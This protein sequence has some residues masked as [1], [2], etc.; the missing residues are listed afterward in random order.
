MKLLVSNVQF[1]FGALDKATSYNEEA[2]PKFYGKFLVRE[3]ATIKDIKAAIK[4]TAIDNFSSVP[5]KLADFLFEPDLDKYPEQEGCLI[6]N[7]AQEDKPKLFNRQGE[8]IMSKDGLIY[9]GCF[10]NVIINLW[11]YTYKGN[12]G[13]SANLNGLQFYAKG[14][15][16]GATA[17]ASDFENYGPETY[18]AEEIEDLHSPLG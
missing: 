1:I 6:L 16:L 18:N 11:S 10:V 9:R 13:I 5:N 12:K 4:K 15:P 14:E 7:A 8:V 17:S 2:T 3:E